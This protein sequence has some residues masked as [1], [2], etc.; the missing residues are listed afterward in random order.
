MEEIEK[1]IGTA[2]AHS[3]KS[4]V[5]KIGLRFDRVVVG[6]FRDIR[7]SIEQDVPKGMAVIMTITAPIKHPSKT[8]DEVI[9][10][11]KDYLKPGMHEEDC[12]LTVYLNKVQLRIAPTSKT[13]TEKFV[14]LVHNPDVEA[15]MLLDLAAQWLVN[16]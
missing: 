1:R 7:Q 5:K 3:G 11:I 4:T 16:E 8:A 6:L 10:K 9:E 12:I 15:S 14:G 2:I 13:Q